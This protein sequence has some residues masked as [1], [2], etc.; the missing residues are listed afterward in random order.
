VSAE[1]ILDRGPRCK[2]WPRE[3]AFDAEVPSRPVMPSAQRRRRAVVVMSETRAAELG[4][5]PLARILSTGVS[6]IS[7]EIMESTPIEASRRA[8][9]TA[10]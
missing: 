9:P 1:R 3:T 7:P 8:S 4:I 6:A 2:D 10:A 5:T